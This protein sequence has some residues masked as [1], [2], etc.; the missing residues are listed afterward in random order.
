VANGETL[1]GD[2]QRLSDVGWTMSDASICGLG[3]TAAS[4]VLSA[5]RLWPE[6]FQPAHPPMSD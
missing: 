5:L 2:A 4:A 3:Q 1:D 6:L